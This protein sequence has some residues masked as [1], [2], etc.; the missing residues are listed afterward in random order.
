MKDSRLI[1]VEHEDGQQPT[2]ERNPSLPGKMDSAATLSSSPRATLLMRRSSA[3]QDGQMVRT[4]V[5]V[6]ANYEEMRD[7]LK[8][9][10][11]S[12]P[13]SNPKSTK[14]SAVKIKP[15]TGGPARSGSMAMDGVPEAREHREVRA[16]PNDASEATERTGLL[17][18]PQITGKD[19][20]QALHQTTYGTSPVKSQQSGQSTV[21]LA[22][23]GNSSGE[24]TQAR[25]NRGDESPTVSAASSGSANNSLRRGLRGTVRSGSITENIV[26]A[27]G[28]RKVIL[29]ASMSSDEG[30][31]AAILNQSKSKSTTDLAPANKK[32]A[33][34]LSSDAAEGSTAS[35]ASQPADGGKKKKNRKKK[36]GGK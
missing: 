1:D 31:A 32:S 2:K 21:I 29:E 3:G 25:E 34:G 14:V 7:H 11:P 13:A 36:K 23:D 8:H 18:K 16:V 12:N 9:L 20:V 19:G 17:A 22:S 6:K 30:D 27:G 26:E 24:Q 5:P 33:E 28:I 15:G 10:G 35:A 4:T